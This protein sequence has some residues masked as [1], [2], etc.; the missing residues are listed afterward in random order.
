MSYAKNRITGFSLDWL[1]LVFAGLM[2]GFQLTAIGFTHRIQNIVIATPEQSSDFA[3]GGELVVL[4]V[5]EIAVL[6][7]G[8]RVYKRLPERWQY[9]IRKALQGL[10]LCYFGLLGYLLLTTVGLGWLT[11]PIYLLAFGLVKLLT[12]YSLLWI[13][14]NLFGLCLGVFITVAGGMGLSPAVIIAIMCAFTI[15]DHIAVNLTD[16]MGELIELSG[17]AS[18]PNVVIIPTTLQFDLGKLKE[19]VVDGE[20]P[21]SVAFVIGVGDFVFPSLLVVSGYVAGG[22]GGPAVGAVGGTT[23]AAIILRDSLEHADGG[24]PALPW[25]NTGA[26]AGFIAGAVVGNVTLVTA[27]GL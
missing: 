8:Y 13:G 9:R 15:Y 11:L 24:L 3:I 10:V 14:F 6:L 20:K 4:A 21:D 27:L 5:I 23:I 25:L 7:L 18:I 1:T 16:I 17:K 19:I 12:R 2:A 22:L 26:I